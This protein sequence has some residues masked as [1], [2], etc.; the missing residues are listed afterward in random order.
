M[1]FF[2]FFFNGHKEEK[3]FPCVYILSKEIFLIKLF[4]FKP[5]HFFLKSLVGKL[6]SF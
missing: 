4:F 3:P 1:Y 2:P 6:E 5:E